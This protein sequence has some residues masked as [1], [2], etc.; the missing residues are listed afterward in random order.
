M[1][2][3]KGETRELVLDVIYMT[4]VANRC[5]ELHGQIQHTHNGEEQYDG[6]DK[7][8]RAMN[9]QLP[10]LSDES[11]NALRQ[12]FE[13]AYQRKQGE[14][15]ARKEWREVARYNR[16][17]AALNRRIAEDR[18]KRLKEGGLT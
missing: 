16:E 11:R 4:K 1:S 2:I 12:V 10:N 3:D 5:G 8:E 18:E 7:F 6:R 14:E 15:K 13:N 17:T 9:A